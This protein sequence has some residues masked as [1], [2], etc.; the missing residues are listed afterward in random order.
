MWW[1]GTTG[2][3]D[4][5]YIL[6][7]RDGDYYRMRISDIPS[8]SG[9]ME[10]LATPV[11]VLYIAGSSS[12]VLSTT[13]SGNPTSTSFVLAGAGVMPEGTCRVLVYNST[14]DSFRIATNVAT[15]PYTVT[16]VSS[17]DNWANGDTVTFRSQSGAGNTFVDVDVSNNVPAGAVAIILVHKLTIST[18]TT[19]LRKYGGSSSHDI[20]RG[21]TQIANDQQY[22]IANA[23]QRFS[24]S[25][26]GNGSSIIN[27]VGWV[28]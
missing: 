20:N 19:R 21:G 24:F 14:R 12:D 27:L 9:G 6:V 26:G 28:T 18:G 1:L 4:G 25:R 8:G 10:L 5:D 16:T 7:A 11:Q 2:Y 15:G 3:D 23:S 17:A 13:I 22:I